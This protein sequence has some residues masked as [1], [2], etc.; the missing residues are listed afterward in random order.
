MN[1]YKI[2]AKK[3]TVNFEDYNIKTYHYTNNFLIDGESVS[4]IIVGT[5]DI[6]N[7]ECAVNI[8]EYEANN[9]EKFN[10]YFAIQPEVIDENLYKILSEQIMLQ[11]E[12]IENQKMLELTQAEI[13]LNQADIMLNGGDYNV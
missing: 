6:I 10:N 12:I 9:F 2:E 5:E 7:E 4:F 13:L 8:T 11:A 3:N 1:Y